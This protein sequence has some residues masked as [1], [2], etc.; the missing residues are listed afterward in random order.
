MKLHVSGESGRSLCER[1]RR[2]ISGI[3][4]FIDRLDLPN[5]F[6][7]GIP[8]YKTIYDRRLARF[9]MG[10]LWTDGVDFDVFRVVHVDKFLVDI[11]A[12]GTGVVESG[13]KLARLVTDL[14]TRNM[15]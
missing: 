11:G 4:V 10:I 8:S 14:M 15:K 7:F 5:F 1:R 13:I 9:R 12:I 3:R 6:P 2:G